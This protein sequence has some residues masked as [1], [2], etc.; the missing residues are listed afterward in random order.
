MTGRTVLVH[1]LVGIKAH[2]A[3]V[4]HRRHHPNASPAR[5]HIGVIVTADAPTIAGRTITDDLRLVCGRKT[6]ERSTGEWRY[7]GVQLPDPDDICLVCAERYERIERSL[8]GAGLV[9]ETS[10][11]HRAA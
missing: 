8:V 6:H 11:A 1:Y 3:A 10:G 4:E 9:A 7:S 2:R 5:V